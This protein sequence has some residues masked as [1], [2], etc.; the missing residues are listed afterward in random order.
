MHFH[1]DLNAYGKDDEMRDEARR[2][3]GIQDARIISEQL[4]ANRLKSI[5][6]E[7]EKKRLRN[8]PDPFASNEPS[9]CDDDSIVPLSEDM[10]LEAADPYGKEGDKEDLASEQDSIDLISLSTVNELDSGEEHYTDSSSDESSTVSEPTGDIAVQYLRVFTK[11]KMMS[12]VEFKITVML[13]GRYKNLWAN[14]NVTSR[15]VTNLA[16]TKS[17]CTT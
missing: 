1:R 3:T 2:Q 6:E 8:N 9:E 17:I 10:P 15:Q 16:L 14:P 4:E 12:G 7:E 11:T 5:A 13:S